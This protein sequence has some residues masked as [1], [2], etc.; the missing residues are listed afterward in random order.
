MTGS[1]TNFSKDKT[2][3]GK[4]ALFFAIDLP[5]WKNLLQ[6]EVL[7]IFRIF[8]DFNINPGRAP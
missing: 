8:S 1:Q 5:C 7:K 4:V 3:S 6:S 2:V